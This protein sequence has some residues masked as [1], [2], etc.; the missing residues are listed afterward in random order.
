MRIRLVIAGAILL[1]G[2]FIARVGCGGEQSTSRAARPATIPSEAKTVE[3]ITRAIDGW[4]GFGCVQ[5]AQFSRWG[6]QVFAAWW[7]PFSGRG[8]CYLEVYYFDFGSGRWKRFVDQLIEGN[9]T[10]LSAEMPGTG[11]TILFRDNGGKVRLT[12][13]LDKYPYKRWW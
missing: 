4:K 3:E 13:P 5:T 11:D 1:S 10:D 8:D 12:C 2:L 7:C 6:R 9:P